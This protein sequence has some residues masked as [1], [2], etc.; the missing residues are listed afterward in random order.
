MQYIILGLGITGY[1]CLKF[2]KNLEIDAKNI[3]VLD[4]R[5]NPPCLANVL[6]E[7]PEVKIMLGDFAKHFTDAAIEQ[8]AIN[9]T[10]IITSPGVDFSQPIFIKLANKQIKLCSDIEI[11]ARHVQAPVVAITGSNGK[12]TT[13]SLLGEMARANNILV[14][15]GGNIGIPVLDLLIDGNNYDLYILE[16]SSFQL[17]FTYSLA[18]KI[19]CILNITDD[20]L[21]IHKTFN[22][23][24]EA[25]HRI[26]LNA[27]M[28]V[29]DQLSHITIPSIVERKISYTDNNQL[30][31]LI[32]QHNLLGKH[33]RLNIQA[34]LVMGQALGFTTETMLMTISN[35]KCLPHRAEKIATINDVLWVNDSK[36]TNVGATIA[37]LDGL[38]DEITGKWIIILGGKDKV[39]DFA[40][41]VDSV[42]QF[43]K[44]VVL[45]GETALQIQMVLSFLPCFVAS[46]MQDAVNK[47][48]TL[49]GSGDGVL[50]APACASFDMFDNYMHRGD[51][52]AKCVNNLKCQDN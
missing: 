32:P 6:N 41:L 46:N 18:T 51:V 35:F 40:A 28:A 21:D 8:I 5:D 4:T 24:C 11:F 14:A 45:L 26:Y 36:A 52:F 10:T 16:L 50:L 42:K 49:S 44:A 17:Q 38:K 9:N 48:F 15:V 13:T 31:D 25:K 37:A 2:L 33:N 47:A 12:S 23:Y 30:F 22:S 3:L 20:H 27:K 39:S 34:A 43:C 1:S 19:S 29:Y 7:F